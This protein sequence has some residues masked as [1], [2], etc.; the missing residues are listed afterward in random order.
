MLA[1]SQVVS[2]PTQLIYSDVSHGS[3]RAWG[4]LSLLPQQDGLIWVSQNW[5]ADKLKCSARQIRY[6]LAELEAQ[7]FLERTEKTHGFYPLYKLLGASQMA[8]E[9]SGDVCLGES[10]SNE[11]G[12]PIGP[13]EGVGN[14]FPTN[15]LNFNSKF[16]LNPQRQ[17]ISGA[18][19][20]QAEALL[21]SNPAW[22]AEFSCFDGRE[23][24]PT[25]KQKVTEAIKRF[26][27]GS[28]A[29]YVKYYLG[30]GAKWLLA[31]IAKLH[32]VLKETQ[33]ASLEEIKAER[34]KEEERRAAYNN[35]FIPQEIQ[36]SDE[37]QNFLK[38]AF[39]KLTRGFRTSVGQQENQEKSDF[40][41]AL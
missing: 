28:L 2:L 14:I 5:L 34:R 37:D 35:R 3:L 23:G 41:F 22:E 16:N 38:D 39:A 4:I 27:Y 20:D 13:S 12:E 40:S 33:P 10:R 1:E 15:K 26:Q 19:E 17:N 18:P 25:L 31:S 7:G 24:R 21:K 11:S 36:H 6:Y 30:C 32:G 29:G 8:N 9:E